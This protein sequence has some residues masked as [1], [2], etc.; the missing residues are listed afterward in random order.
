[1]EELPEAKKGEYEGIVKSTLIFYTSM[2]AMT[3]EIVSM[4]LG[5]YEQA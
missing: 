1:M 2:C 4:A 3:A 5:S